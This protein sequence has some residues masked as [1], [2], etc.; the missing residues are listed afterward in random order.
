MAALMQVFDC[1]VGFPVLIRM[2]AETTA[3]PLVSVVE[4]NLP[5][6]TIQPPNTNPVVGGIRIVKP[7]PLA[8]PLDEAG[9][10]IVPRNLKVGMELELPE[11][12]AEPYQGRVVD[13]VTKLFKRKPDGEYELGPTLER[14]NVS[15]YAEVG[16]FGERGGQNSYR[17]AFDPTSIKEDGSP[18]PFE[19]AFQ[20]AREMIW[21]GPELF[22]DDRPDTSRGLN[23]FVVVVRDN[24]GGVTWTT[25]HI[26]L[27]EK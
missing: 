19:E 12:N 15:W 2:T 22:D 8:A 11:A 17:A 6:D 9:T 20:L 13:P 5:I 4:L 23:R 25:A 24:R 16:S 14:L 1:K 18:V 27:E 26:G 7:G 21:K 10:A 3:G